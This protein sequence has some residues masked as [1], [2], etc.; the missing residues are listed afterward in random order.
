MTVN[1]IIF[2]R[3]SLIHGGGSTV[4]VFLLKKRKE[5]P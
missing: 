2:P 4:I 5:K 3:E 1:K